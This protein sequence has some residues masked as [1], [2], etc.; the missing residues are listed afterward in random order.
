MED[1]ENRAVKLPCD[2]YKFKYNEAIEI[3]E[4]KNE[5]LQIEDGWDTHSICKQILEK[6][7][8]MIRAVF[9]AS[10][11]ALLVNT[12]LKC[13]TSVF[14]SQFLLTDLFKKKKSMQS[15]TTSSSQ[16]QWR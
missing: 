6:E 2:V 13:T 9:A 8:M 1:E 4:M 15:P 12:F 10:G 5:T 7:A 14:N 3:P 11:K 16:Y